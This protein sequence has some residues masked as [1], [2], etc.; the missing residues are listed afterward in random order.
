MQGEISLKVNLGAN[1][2]KKHSMELHLIFLFSFFFY[3]HVFG[4]LHRIQVHCSG[5]SGSE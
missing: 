5:R 4:L 1:Y 3:E 2:R